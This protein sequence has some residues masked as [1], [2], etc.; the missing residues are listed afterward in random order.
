VTSTSTIPNLRLDEG[1]FT[2][3][4]EWLTALTEWLRKTHGKN[5]YWITSAG[6]VGRD[7]QLLPSRDSLIMKGWLHAYAR[8]GSNEAHI[9]C[10][11]WQRHGSA[12]PPLMLIQIKTEM[13]MAHAIT[14]AG[15]IT[16]AIYR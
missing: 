3:S 6:D 5:V 2:T 7:L 16:Q 4:G 11:D 9:V 10:L 15:M 1:H 14:I 13:G 8:P 12:A